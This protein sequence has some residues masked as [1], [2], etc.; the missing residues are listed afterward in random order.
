MSLNV[1]VGVI[2]VF[3]LM[4]IVACV[5][6]LRW[7]FLSMQGR[8]WPAV[9]LSSLAVVIG[10]LGIT[11]IH[12]IHSQTVNGQ[13]QWHFD[14]RWFFLVPLLLGALALIYTIWKGQRS[15]HVP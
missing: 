5:L 13:L 3:W 1:F 10:Y 12:I 4:S 11:R 15:A 2:G 6:A 9:I 7:S 14:S 8:F